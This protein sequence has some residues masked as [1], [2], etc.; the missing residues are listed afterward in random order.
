MKLVDALVDNRMVS[1]GMYG[2]ELISNAVV[3]VNGLQVNDVNFD[4]DDGTSKVSIE[5]KNMVD[6]SA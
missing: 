5:K 6:I 4:L 1:S 3:K 2:R